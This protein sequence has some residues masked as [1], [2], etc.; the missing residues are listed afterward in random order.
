MPSR[1]DSAPPVGEDPW[2]GGGRRHLA[3]FDLNLL[4]ALQ[5]LLAEQNVTRA[6]HS[7]GVTQPAMS[8]SL[9]RLRRHFKDDLLVRVA[10]SYA[11]TPLAIRLADL[12]EPACQSVEEV[13]HTNW[14]F[15]PARTSREFQ[16]VMTDYVTAVLGEAISL[17]LAQ[18]APQA[19]LHIT[20]VRENLDVDY[21]SS[22]HLVDVLIAPTYTPFKGPDV[23]VSS[24]FK[25]R[26]VCVVDA[27]S[28]AGLAGRLEPEALEQL[29]WV[30][31]YHRGTADASLAPVPRQ[32][33]L[34]PFRPRVAVR[35]ESYRAVPHFVVGTDHVALMQERLALRARA[36]TNLALL[37]CPYPTEA[38]EE[39]LWWSAEVNEDPGHRWFRDLLAAAASSL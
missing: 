37:P 33:A 12:V 11:L 7:V 29:S 17:R 26:W 5:A 16:L 4:V 13:L 36:T 20:M 3:N 22:R 23:R 25:D 19:R 34:F 21:Q 8:A 9:A 39:G 10:N 2:E 14:N 27:T 35:V 1:P 18:L 30:V 15:S 32:L 31:A 6:A 38:I 24:L 28:P